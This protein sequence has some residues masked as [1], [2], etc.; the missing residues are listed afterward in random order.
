MDF[1]IP[2]TLRGFPDE[3]TGR[4]ASRRVSVV[5]EESSSQLCLSMQGLDGV[6]IAFDY[7][8]ALTE[9]QRGFQSSGVLTPT[10]DDAAVGV[11]MSPLVKRDGKVLTHIVLSA[12]VVVL[13]DTPY[14]GMSGKYIIAH[15]LA[16]VHEHYLRDKQLPGTLLQQIIYG[17][18][19]VFLYVTA[20]A[21]WS[22]YAACYFSAAMSPEHGILLEKTFIS[23]L[24]GL[25][26]KILEAKRDW[27]SDKDF[28]KVWQAISRPVAAMLKYASY[29][30]GH[31]AGLN[32]PLAEIAPKASMLMRGND[33]LSPRF[34]EL[35]AA[36]ATMM[37]TFEQ[38]KGLDAFQPLK[39]VIRNVLNNCGI[40]IQATSDGSLFIWVS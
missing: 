14:E 28:G 10:V 6:T 13:I 15:E 11:A 38:W 39:N 2:F 7:N 16:H 27:M 35:V 21:C 3:A 24:G 26:S 37:D 4:E 33:W 19:E 12:A 8:A 20:E 22:E 18:D 32:K 31:S 9:I 25:R 23:A 5:L 1:Q 34:E 36:L 40:T 30:M 29:L 17:A